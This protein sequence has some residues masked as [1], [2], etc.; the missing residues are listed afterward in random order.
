VHAAIIEKCLWRCD[1]DTYVDR[2]PVE[3]RNNRNDRAIR[4][5]M[6]WYQSHFAENSLDGAKVVLLTNDKAHLDKSFKQGIIV[7]TG[8]A[9]ATLLQVFCHILNTLIL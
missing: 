1:R 3:S 6:S 7:Y 4:S 2:D 8:T 9:D 5:A